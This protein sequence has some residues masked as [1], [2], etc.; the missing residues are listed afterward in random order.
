[1]KKKLIILA[2]IGLLIAST[3]QAA[4]DEFGAPVKTSTGNLYQ[5]SV[6]SQIEAGILSSSGVK[7]V[8]KLRE[9]YLLITDPSTASNLDN[10]GLKVNFIASDISKDEM[11]I[12]NRKDRANVDKYD[13]IFEENQLRIFRVDFD[14][15]ATGIDKPQLSRMPAG[16]PKI[17]YK[18]PVRIENLADKSMMDLQTLISN[19]EQDSLQSYTEALQ[20]FYRRNQG[21]TGNYASRDWIAA[22]FADFGYDS[23]WID[24]FTTPTQCMNVHAYKIGT[25]LPEHYVIVGA[26]RDGVWNSPAAD[27]NGSGTAAVLEIARILKDIDTD[28]TFIFSLYDAEEDGLLGSWHYADAAAARGDSIIHMFNMDMIGNYTNTTHFD[29]YYGSDL[30]HPQLLADLAD[31]LLGMTGHFAGSIGASDHHPFLQNGYSALLLIEY[32]FSTV[33]HTPQDSTTYMSFPYHTLCAKS[34]L[35][36]S[37]VIS[38]TYRQASVAFDYPEG[39]PAMLTPNEETVF[40]VAVTGQ[41]DGIPVH[42]SGELHYSVNGGAY[43]TVSMTEESSH[44]YEAVIP[45]YD[46]DSIITY[47]FSAN[48]TENGT[49]YDPDPSTPYRA[50]SATD[51]IIIIDDNFQTDQGW[52]T[53]VVGA[54]SGQWQRG[55]PVDDDGWDYDPATD[56]DGSGM[57]YLTQNQ[58]GN[59]DVDGG[60]VRLISPVLDMSSGGD[61][62]YDYYLY[63]TDET[64]GIDRLLV[65]INNNGGV[66]TWTEIA[67][68][69]THGGLD[70]HHHTIT[71]A[72]IVA[73]GVP[74]TSNMKVRFTANDSDPQSIVEAGV[75]GFKISDFECLLPLEVT[76]MQI[77]EDSLTVVLIEDLTVTG[78]F[79]ATAGETTNVYDIWLTNPNKALFQPSSSTYGFVINIDDPGIVS[80]TE[81][82]D[83]QFSL[84]GVAEGQTSMTIDIVHSEISDYTSPGID[85]T[86]NLPLIC[87]DA[88]NDDVVNVSDAVFI[89][90][91][92]FVG[93]SAPDPL[94]KGDVNCDGDVNVSDAVYIVNYIFVYGSA[95]CDT[96]GDEIPDC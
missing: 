52:T 15:L 10:L 75:D 54:S 96:D 3:Q 5:V 62:E 81:T 47:Y 46:C 69:D 83:W 44:Y 56:G 29:I 63:L 40:H 61:V 11:A 65:E 32:E 17:D 13:L 71:E 70:W 59:T 24:S 9:S 87:G 30:T 93:G 51:Q 6:N 80:Y 7:A 45:A 76:G 89:I 68:H 64:G 94:E 37:Y 25:K 78:G 33:Y 48:E 18:K 41:Y 36:T 95:P 19:I 57:C 35:A 27:D 22:K 55:V 20:S 84:T 8:L 77:F 43:T 2:I 86:V 38:Q 49:F 28:V 67:R 4:A 42:G 91:Y 85:V 12:D 90:N 60:S 73:E 79:D 53:E 23:I 34:A 58:T 88:T 50:V 92:V 39:T 26:H 16:N 66:G 31:S 82:G 1:M 14:Q 21:S 72:E 74:F